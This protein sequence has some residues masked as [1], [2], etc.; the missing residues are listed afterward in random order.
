MKS[1]GQKSFRLLKKIKDPKFE[2]DRLEFYSLSLFLGKRDFQILIR[3]AELNYCLLLEDYVFA[4]DIEPSQQKELLRYIFDD[5][6]LLL[7]NFWKSIQ[8]V[9]KN[10]NFTFVPSPLFEEENIAAYL[11]LNTLFDP[12]TD[13]VMLTYHKQLDMINVFSVPRYIVEMIEEIYPGNKPSYIHQ[14]SPLI[15]GLLSLNQPEMRDIVLFIDRF[16]LHIMVA[17]DKKLVFYNQYTIRKF[18]DY[19]KYIRLVANELDIDL[20]RSVIQ[21]Y[22]FLGNNTPHLQE[23]RKTIPYLTLGERPKNFNFG[24][25][26]DEILDHQ[27][28]DVLSTDVMRF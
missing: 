25:V 18:S 27:Y 9:I 15:S 22:G 7:A 16:G 12:A 2:I 3:D 28:F 4:P 26:F 1:I 5:H 17:Y 11:K 20:D 10:R 19:L 8:F 21:L 14:S 6:H 13:E 23:L 24:Y